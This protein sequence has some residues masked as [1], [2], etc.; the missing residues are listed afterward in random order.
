MALDSGKSATARA[1]AAINTSA[2]SSSSQP[3]MALIFR[4]MGAWSSNDGIASGVG[5]L[6]SA[7]RFK[8]AARI[9]ILRAPQ[10]DAIG[11]VVASCHGMNPEHIRPL[12]RQLQLTQ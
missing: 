2:S 4:R 3:W 12:P 10:S 8:F 7:P 6:I 5:I 11:V 9:V 1:A